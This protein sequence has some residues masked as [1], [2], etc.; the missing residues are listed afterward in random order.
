LTP[1]LNVARAGGGAGGA[2]DPQGGALCA[3]RVRPRPAPP[4]VLSSA[5]RV[6]ALAGAVRVAPSES[7]R[8]SRAGACRAR[9]GRR[10]ALTCGMRPQVRAHADHLLRAAARREPGAP[11]ATRQMEQRGEERRGENARACCARQTH[12]FCAAWACCGAAAA[13]HSLGSGAP[14]YGQGLVTQHGLIFFLVGLGGIGVRVRRARGGSCPSRCPTTRASA[15][16]GSRSRC[17]LIP[18]VKAHNFVIMLHLMPPRAC[19]GAGHCYAAFAWHRACGM[20]RLLVVLVSPR[21]S[22][23]LGHDVLDWIFDRQVPVCG[24]GRRN[25]PALCPE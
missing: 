12:A 1:G 11:P 7:R 16:P 14:H 10:H 17:V 3:G 20:V 22:V 24:R 25:L 5:R 23:A 9:C 21:P 2:G 13:T 19:A 6:R 15:P 4:R 8:P 18:S